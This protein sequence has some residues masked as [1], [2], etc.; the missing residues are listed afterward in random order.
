MDKFT[1]E[2]T[3]YVCLIATNAK[4]NDVDLPETTELRY[5]GSLP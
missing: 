1:A 2:H 4:A 5:L 3:S